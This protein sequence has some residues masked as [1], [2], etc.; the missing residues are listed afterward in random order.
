MIKSNIWPVIPPNKQ[1]S[2]ISSFDFS[3]AFYDTRDTWVFCQVCHSSLVRSSPTYSQESC[4]LPLVAH[5][6]SRD[7]SRSLTSPPHRSLFVPFCP[8]VTD[9]HYGMVPMMQHRPALKNIQATTTK[10]RRRRCCCLCSHHVNAP[11]SWHCHHLPWAFSWDDGCGLWCANR[12]LIS[13]EIHI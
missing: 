4:T 7:C 5:I 2:N 10:S 13:S 1:V 12:N 11:P 9:F 3:E 6:D 8:F